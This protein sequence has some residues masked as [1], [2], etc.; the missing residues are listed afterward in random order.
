[1]PYNNIEIPEKLPIYLQK[2]MVPFPYMIFP[3]FVNSND[4]QIFECLEEAV[5]E[6]RLRTIVD[7]CGRGWNECRHNN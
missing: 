6:E 3:L 4:V 2:E 1:M 7:L 5:I